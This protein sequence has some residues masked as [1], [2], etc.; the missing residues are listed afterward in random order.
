VPPD[1]IV[2]FLAKR[3]GTVEGIVLSGGEPTIRRSIVDDAEGVRQLGYQLKLDTNGLEPDVMAAVA[4]DYV[5][6]DVKTL[7][8]AYGQRLGCSYD[9]AAERL[10]RAI[11]MVRQMG[12]RAEVRI[13]VAPGIVDRDVVAGLAPLL[14]GVARV[15]LQPVDRRAALLDPSYSLRPPVPPE[16]IRQYRDLLA[17]VV[18]ACVVRTAG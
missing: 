14:R 11:D 6:L 15:Y 1:E 9:D 10:S 13:T 18:G 3:R 5:A 2:S 16:E 8:G 7:P 12:D 4:A 17:P